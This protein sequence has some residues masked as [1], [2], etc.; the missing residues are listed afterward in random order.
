MITAVN[1]MLSDKLTKAG[2]DVYEEYSAAKPLKAGV[3]TALW[4]TERL[5]LGEYRQAAN[6]NSKC[7]YSL[8]EGDE[9]FDEYKAELDEM[10]ER[11][12]ENGVITIPNVTECYLGEA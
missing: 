9:N 10:F 12:A 2:F 6:A 8:K 1:T 3:Y 5:T 7:S 4:R 11:Y